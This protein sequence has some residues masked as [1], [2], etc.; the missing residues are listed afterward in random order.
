MC[1][2][3]WTASTRCATRLLGMSRLDEREFSVRWTIASMVVF[4]TLEV[5]LG[6]IAGEYVLH[7]HGPFA[8]TFAVQALL[9]LVSYF[10][11][12]MIIG[13]VSPGVRV[14]EPAVGAFL[15]MVLLLVFTLFTPYTFLRFSLTK[16]ILGGSIAF[17]LAML[18]ARL[19]ER[20]A[21]NRLD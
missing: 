5:V 13:F 1:L 10:I 16:L 3:T 8:L 19:G 9:N 14:L 18:G 21:G 12:G 2:R 20:L 17:G 15:C 6:G 11:G 4:I 7:R